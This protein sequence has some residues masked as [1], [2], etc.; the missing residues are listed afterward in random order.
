MSFDSYIHHTGII[1]IPR[2]KD[3]VIKNMIPNLDEKGLKNINIY[4]FDENKMGCKKNNGNDNFSIKDLY[5][6]TKGANETMCNDLCKN[7]C[8]NHLHIINQAKKLN[9]D[10]VL[11]FEDDAR[12]VD[13]LSSEKISRIIGSGLSRLQTK[14]G[15]TTKNL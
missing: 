10:N 14:Y 1:T 3:N 13:N 5:N 2:N 4:V 15:R 7:L 8:E 6:I 12:F 9:V 11:I